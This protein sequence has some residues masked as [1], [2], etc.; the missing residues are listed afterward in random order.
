[1]FSR[2]VLSSASEE[3]VLKDR[4][5][6]GGPI[7]KA[8]AGTATFLIELEKRRSIKV[9]K[10]DSASPFPL[11]GSLFGLG[12]ILFFFSLLQVFG[13]SMFIGLTLTFFAGVCFSLFSPAF[14]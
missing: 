8:K 3:A 1:M 6:G 12:F 14:N 9:G 4:E 5:N 10:L 2:T 13:K 7:R 11:L